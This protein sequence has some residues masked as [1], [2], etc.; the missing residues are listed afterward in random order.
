MFL[1]RLNVEPIL[2]ITI[3]ILSTTTLGVLKA[4]YRKKEIQCGCLGTVFQLPMTEVTLIENFI[5]IF[6]SI[7][8]IISLL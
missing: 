7:F 2:Y 4:L 6:M 3:F 1:L 8:M 5:M